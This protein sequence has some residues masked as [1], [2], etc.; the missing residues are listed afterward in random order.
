MPSKRITAP[1]DA[2]PKRS[3]SSRNSGLTRGPDSWIRSRATARAIRWVRVCSGVSSSARCRYLN[4]SPIWPLPARI[5]GA[6]NEDSREREIIPL[7][8]VFDIMA[9][10]PARYRALVLMA[11]FTQLRFG[12]LAGLRRDRLDLDAC[13]VQVTEASVQPNKGGLLVEPPKSRAGLRTVTFPA[14]IV[15]DLRDHL[16]HYA[17]PGLRGLVF[18]GPKGGQLRRNNLNPVWSAAVTAV[19][20]PDAHFHDLRHT[21][22]T[23]AAITGATTKE[24]MARLG[25]S[26]TRAAMIY[27]HATTERDKVIADALGLL[28]SNARPA[29]S[30]PQ[31]A[32]R[33]TKG[34]RKRS[35]KR[36]LSA[37]RATV[38]ETA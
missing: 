27:Q 12:E 26:S 29:P 22:G 35:K 8:L 21:G 31:M 7:P 9:K 18:V 32:Q 5:D 16:K 3:A 36:A 15:P 38:I 14:A 37:E 4:A 28:V 10:L 30:G 24:L 6:G 13:T 2:A 19:G 20:L 11:T 33:A 25:H 1:Y 34:N 17:E 23:L